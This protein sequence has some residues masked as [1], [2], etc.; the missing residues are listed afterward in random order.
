VPRLIMLNGPPAS[1]KSTLAQRYAD[2][3]SMTLNLD[4]DRIRGMLGRWADDPTRAGEL[5]RTIACA[6]AEGHLCA[7]HD[8][9]IPQFVARP[10][11]LERLE[12][13]ADRIGVTFHEVVVLTAPDD[14]AGRFD[15]RTRRRSDQ[16]HLDAQQLLDAQGGL[17]AL[18]E[19]HD[20]LMALVATRPRARI[21]ETRTG[22]VDE[23][24]RA[25]LA[26]L[27]DRR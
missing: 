1:G 17:G 9:V 13:L 22:H 18:P 23:A 10:A 8:V 14:L 15:E 25:L 12:H 7:G 16:V 2:D 4:V 27:D 11:F 26:V 5:A 3:R 24:Y 6:A 21:L 20:R 19:L